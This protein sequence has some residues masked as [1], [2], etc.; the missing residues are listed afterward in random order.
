[1]TE[2]GASHSMVFAVRLASRLNMNVEDVLN[3]PLAKAVAYDSALQ[4]M[5]GT[6]VATIDITQEDKD[7]VKFLSD[8]QK[9]ALEKLKSM[10]GLQ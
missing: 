5:D 3:L 1:V 8:N 9:G 2:L 4:V 6:R 10:R 7:I